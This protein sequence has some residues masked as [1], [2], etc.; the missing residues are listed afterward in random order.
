MYSLTIFVIGND[1]S[2]ELS[3]LSQ[4]S[5]MLSDSESVYNRMA[6]TLRM[7]IFERAK[8][9]RERTKQLH[10]FQQIM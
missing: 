1:E 6:C 10:I 7:C 4:R 5:L 3:V 9:I 8:V 2:A